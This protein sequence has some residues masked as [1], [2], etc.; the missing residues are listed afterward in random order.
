MY[1][2]RSI[3]ET[4]VSYRHTCVASSAEIQLIYRDNQHVGRSLGISCRS[5]VSLQNSL[6][7]VYF[8]DTVLGAEGGGPIQR[9]PG[10]VGYITA[11]L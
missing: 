5:R 10:I 7:K 2:Y 6:H 3:R 8:Q 1:K 11:K 4:P 9:Y